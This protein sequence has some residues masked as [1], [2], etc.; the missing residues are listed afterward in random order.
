MSI[1]DFADSI[2]RSAIKFVT[3]GQDFARGTTSRES[4]GPR[5]LLRTALRVAA[6][7]AEALGGL[8]RGLNG[9]WWQETAN[10]LEVCELF[11]NAGGLKSVDLVQAV[12]Q[13]DS[14]DPFS[15]PW[16]LEGVGY[17]LAGQALGSGRPCDK[18][19][20][21][22]QTAGI[23]H[24]ALLTLHTGAGMAFGRAALAE[25]A[26]GIGPMLQRHWQRC[27][28]NAGGHWAEM[29]FESLGFVAAT[30]NRELI[31]EIRRELGG[32]PAE[33]ADSFWHGVGRGM[34]FL[35]STLAPISAMRRYVLVES[36]RMAPEGV[37]RKN[38][39]AGIAWAV[40][41]TNL[42]HPEVIASWLEEQEEEA[43]FRNG[44]ASAL[45]FWLLCVPE[46]QY[47]SRLSRY[48]PHDGS[49]RLESL[50]ETLVVSSCED[51]RVWSAGPEAATSAAILFRAGDR[52]QSA[53]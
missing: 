30:L 15:R 27:K 45:A 6:T 47:V 28:D 22:P 11:V 21:G 23:P 49:P 26:R 19:L 50:W 40:T 14:L 9:A 33:L 32:W 53:S 17:D 8:P 5:D 34:Y 3:I 20:Q 13:C 51:A 7:S 37:G 46:D 48:R 42:R 41:L 25:R 1:P 24:H 16:V 44:V 4:F 35:P 43:A 18:L 31:P 52:F 12:R 10:K 29:M 38:V 2:R 39:F 36:R